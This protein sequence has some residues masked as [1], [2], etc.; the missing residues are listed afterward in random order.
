M[1]KLNKVFTDYHLYLVILGCITNLAFIV[2]T[3]LYSEKEGVTITFNKA[4]FLLISYLIIGLF[5]YVFFYDDV[6]Y[7]PTPEAMGWASEVID[8]PNGNA[9]L[10][11]CLSLRISP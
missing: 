8:S 1:E 5:S 3:K 10:R 4:L 11:F 6:N 2:I 9:L 7:P